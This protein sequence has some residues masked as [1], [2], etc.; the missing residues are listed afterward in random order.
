ME[1]RWSAPDDVLIRRGL[2]GMGTRSSQRSRWRRPT[3]IRLFWRTRGYILVSRAR[4]NDESW[5]SVRFPTRI[6]IGELEEAADDGEVDQNLV[7]WSTRSELSYK[8]FACCSE[9]APVHRIVKTIR[10]TPCK[11]GWKGVFPTRQQRIEAYDDNQ[12]EGILN[13]PGTNQV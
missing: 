5:A 13:L 9:E 2:A 3:R 11:R 10:A 7:G 1:C 12:A 4:Y 6:R 8:V